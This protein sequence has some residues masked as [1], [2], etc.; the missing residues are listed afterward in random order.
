M[1]IAVSKIIIRT[2]N[3]TLLVLTIFLIG[4]FTKEVFAD[5]MISYDSVPGFVKYIRLKHDDQVTDNCWTNASSVLARAR[6]RLENNDVHVIDYDPVFPSLFSPF[7]QISAVGYR[8]GGL[9][10]GNVSVQVLYYGNSSYGGLENKPKYWFTAQQVIFT[11][12]SV[13]SSGKNFNQQID[14]FIDGSVSEFLANAVAS[15]RDPIVEE[16]FQTYPS[17]GSPPMTQEEWDKYLS[18]LA[19]QKN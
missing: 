5:E 16:F 9:C 15:R 4:F 7:L 6:L 1:I 3:A 8:T 11:R 19:P 14:D 2:F 18:T 13:F 12:S 17:F 10:V